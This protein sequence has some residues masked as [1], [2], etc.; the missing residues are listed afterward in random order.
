MAAILSRP[1]CVKTC[2]NREE[3]IQFGLSTNFLAMLSSVMHDYTATIIYK[4]NTSCISLTYI[5]LQENNYHNTIVAMINLKRCR[6]FQSFD[7]IRDM[8]MVSI[9]SL[10]LIS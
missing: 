6:T 3:V 8:V 10:K 7:L 4:Q 9:P 2:H 1:Q 5:Y